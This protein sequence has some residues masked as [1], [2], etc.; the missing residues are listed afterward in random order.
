MEIGVR[1]AGGLDF[2]LLSPRQPLTATP[3]AL[4]ADLASNVLPA[5]ITGASLSSNSITGAKIAPGQVVKGLNGLADLVALTAGTNVSIRAGTGNDL[6]ISATPG[7]VLTNA[8]WGISGNAGTTPGVNFVGTTD[9]QPLEF[10]AG[11]Q[12]ALR[13]EYNSGAPN[14]IGGGAANSAGLQVQGGTISGGTGN[15]LP[16]AGNASMQPTI[17]GGN[18]NTIESWAYQATIGGGADNRIQYDADAATIP[19]GKGNLIG[20]NADYSVISGGLNN[21]I[22]NG[23]N[24]AVIAGGNNNS[25]AASGSFAAGRNA[26]VMAGHTGSF[27]WG[28]GTTGAFSTRSNRFEVLATGGANFYTGNG[29]L[30]GVEGV[31]SVPS[32]L[33]TAILGISFDPNGSG[34]VGIA[35][36]GGSGYGV[37]GRSDQ[38]IGGFFNG[39][40]GIE[41]HSSGGLAG[42]FD[43]PVRVNGDAT[44]TGS[45][46]VTG[47]FHLNSG[48]TQAA[49]DTSG[50]LS[51]GNTTRQM[52]NLYNTDYGIGVQANTEYF[53]SA[54][55]FAWFQGGAHNNSETNAGGGSVLMTL[56]PTTGL[57][58]NGAL[59]CT[60]LNITG[61][62]DVAEPF[63]MDGAEVPCGAVV[64]IDDQQSGR[65]KLSSRAYDTCVAG[66]VSG[67]NGIHPGL[68]LRQVGA[69]EEGRNVALSGRVYVLAE[70]A[71]GPIRPGDLLTSSTVPGHAM[72]V[73]DPARA[74]GAVLGK[75]M[76]P[77]AHGRGLVLVLVTLQ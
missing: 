50:N 31:G 10:R 51:F 30:V 15:T 74:Q 76:S 11:N 35:N 16:T 5:S 42:R 3:Y 2:T 59:S 47:A 20:T 57:A 36:N 65:L 14:V 66:V 61:G 40:A 28:D 58:I 73:S 13:L 53:R 1:P 60:V 29:S 69:L 72:K 34:V 27:L 55:N 67:A 44:V 46:N 18:G 24:H 25:V 7:T 64:V 54:R 33:S 4:F 23:V 8:G 38:G 9:G 21:T 48:A 77:L 56:N 37:W 17:G 32:M 52:L 39:Y 49:F 70:A 12:R 6:I 63:A 41:A 19:G 22:T 26:H 62:A 68:S 75:A 43:G 71:N 45:L